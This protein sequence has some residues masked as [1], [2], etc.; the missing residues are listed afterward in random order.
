MVVIMM[1]ASKML[2]AVQALDSDSVSPANTL[3]SKLLELG[4]CR[5][6]MRLPRLKKQTKDGWILNLLK[7]GLVRC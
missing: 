6:M 2:A 4:E 5:E 7:V 1:V 3:L